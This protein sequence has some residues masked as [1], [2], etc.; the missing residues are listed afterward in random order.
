MGGLKRV[1]AEKV[2]LRGRKMDK[3][4]QAHDHPAGSGNGLDTAAWLDERQ[5]REMI[6]TAAFLRAQRRGFDRGTELE[7]WVAAEAE[8]D[9]WLQAVDRSDVE[10]P[11]FE[12]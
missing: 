10:P 4:D 12:E 9:R 1:A 6:A 2:R 3:P 11:L 7:D 8:I 5:R